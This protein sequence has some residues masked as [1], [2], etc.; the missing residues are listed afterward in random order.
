MKERLLDVLAWLAW[1]WTVGVIL[2]AIAVFF[3]SVYDELRIEGE[4]LAPSLFAFFMGAIALGPLI[5]QWVL[6]YIITGFPRLLPWQRP[7]PDEEEW[8]NQ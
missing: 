7:E 5:C 8:W 4:T 3:S 6:F 2:F 1:L